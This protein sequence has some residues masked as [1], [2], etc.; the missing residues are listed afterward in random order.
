MTYVSWAVLYE[1]ATDR[2]YF[3][4][5]IPRV[6]EEIVLKCGIRL[7]TIPSNPAVLLSRD[8]VEKVAKEACEAKDAFHLCFIQADTGGRDLESK[9]EFRSSAYCEAMRVECEW[10][11]A[12]CIVIAPRKETEAWILADGVAVTSALGYSGLP[13]SIGLPATAVAAQQLADPKSTLRDAMQIVRGRRR[14][15]SVDDLFPAIALRQSLDAL[16]S[17]NSFTAFEKNLYLALADIGCVRRTG[18][19][20]S[21]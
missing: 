16:R 5:L 7:S 21:G 9:L 4:V 6:M 8:T 3:D 12:R 14:T 13:T 10:P 15:I 11:P 18:A 20:R 17:T 19:P 2:A 1:G